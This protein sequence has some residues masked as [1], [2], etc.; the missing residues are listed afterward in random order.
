[1]PYIYKITN[2][3]NNKV[4]IGKT[5]Q[6][7]ADRW[8]IHCYDYLKRDEEKRPLYSAIKKYGIQSFIIE[9]IEEITDI[10]LINEREQYWIEY[11]DSFKN[12]YNA[13]KGGDGKHYADY[14]L[15]YNLYT[16]EN[17][18]FEK[19]Q[20]ITSYDIRTIQTA[21]KTFNISEE[22]IKKN[23]FKKLS[24]SV[25]QID[26]DTDEIINIFPSCS[27]AHRQITGNQGKTGC[28]SISAVCKGKRKTAYGY[29]WKYV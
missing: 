21:L 14:E 10:N 25:A 8:K 19:I 5:L 11:Y 18:T 22:E 4:Y 29:K 26:K 9:E 24:K 6:T 23:K 20:E 3:I 17:L 7:I 27:E 16:E 15:I 12:G 1:M 13:T 2:K 28:S